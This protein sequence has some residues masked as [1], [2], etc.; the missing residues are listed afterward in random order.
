VAATDAGTAEAAQP[1]ARR[2]P[3]A[4][5]LFNPAADRRVTSLLVSV[6]T[7]CGDTPPDQ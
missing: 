7:Y 6:F 2:M 5:T 1:N 3:E 4:A